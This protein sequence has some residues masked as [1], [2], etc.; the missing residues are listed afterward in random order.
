VSNPKHW[1]SLLRFYAL[2]CMHELKSVKLSTCAIGLSFCY[3]IVKLTNGEVYGSKL[4]TSF[5]TSLA[6]IFF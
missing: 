4:I 3:I 6:K 5:G 2:Y 1:H